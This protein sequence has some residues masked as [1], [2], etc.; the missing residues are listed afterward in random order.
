MNDYLVAML[1]DDGG[2][3]Y[4][5]TI[6]YGDVEVRPASSD[7]AGESDLI[8][9]SAEKNQL[10]LSTKFNSRVCCIVNT[11]GIDEAVELAIVKFEKVLDLLSSNFV[12]SKVTLA[13][14]G[15]IKNLNTGVYTY[16]E[17]EK[18][19]FSNMFVTPQVTDPVTLQNNYLMQQ[20]NELSKSYFN[21]LHWGRNASKENNLQLKILFKWFALEALFK[22]N[23]NDN[24]AD[25]MRWFLGFPNG[26]QAQIVKS[27][28]LVLQ[29][30]SRYRKWRGWISEALKDIREFRNNSTHSGFRYFDYEYSMLKT[31][32]LLMTLGLS[33]CQSA[34][35]YSILQRIETVDEFKEYIGI[36][37]EQV[38]DANDILNNILFSI[39]NHVD[40]KAN[41]KH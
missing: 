25:T 23:D 14:C 7:I 33:R 31:Y 29:Q 9:K 39:E 24:V 8:K 26:N 1:L 18:E 13:N 19:P 38:A 40:N 3:I 5:E 12:I 35:R 34:V 4:S 6:V 37:F 30:D 21:S 41:I 22:K 28:A 32:D 16:L 10:V 17:S 27:T 11:V 20:D 2:A 15:F 36:I